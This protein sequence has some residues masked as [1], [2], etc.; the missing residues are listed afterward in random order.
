VKSIRSNALDSEPLKVLAN[1]LLA[2]TCDYCKVPA[3]LMDLCGNITLDR[4]LRRFKCERCNKKSYLRI[5]L[6][7]PMEATMGTSLEHP[8]R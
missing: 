8:L 6:H 2:V 5:A 1:S 3:D 7:F 4:V